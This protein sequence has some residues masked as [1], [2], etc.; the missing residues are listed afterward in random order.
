LA[1][2]KVLG[3]ATIRDNIDKDTSRRIWRKKTHKHFKRCVGGLVKTGR[4]YGGDKY[5]H[6]IAKLLAVCREVLRDMPQSDVVREGGREQ[7]VERHSKYF[8][9]TKHRVS[10]VSGIGKKIVSKIDWYSEVSVVRW[11]Y[12]ARW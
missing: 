7:F 5:V 9:K 10:K 2:G 3:L 11:K 1:T 8:K 12:V 6:R 4:A